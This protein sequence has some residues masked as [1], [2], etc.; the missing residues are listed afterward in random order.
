MYQRAQLR[1]HLRQILGGFLRVRRALRCI[2]PGEYHEEEVSANL[3]P[4]QAPG[5]F[6]MPSENVREV[7]KFQHVYNI[8]G[9]TRTIPSTRPALRSYI[10]STLGETG[11]PVASA[12]VR[13]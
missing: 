4:K 12:W 7:E 6:P 11:I 1:G 13:I 8:V 2:E 10:R 9:T 3:F 5:K